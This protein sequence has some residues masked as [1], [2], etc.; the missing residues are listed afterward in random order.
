MQLVESGPEDGIPVVLIHG[1]LSTGR[2]Y[3]HLFDVAPARYRLLAPDMRGF[4][5]T[6]RVPI[7][8]TRGLRDWADDTAALLRRAGHHRAAA[9]RRLVDRRRRDRRVRARPPGRVADVDRSGRPVRL[10]RHEARRHAALRGLRRLR[11]RH[12]QPGVHRAAG[13]RRP[14]RRTA[15]PRRATSEQLLLARR[16]PRAARARGD[17]ARRD[18]EVGRPATTATRATRPPP[19]TGPAS[20]PA[21]AASSTRSPRSTATGRGSSTSTPS[22]RSCGRTA[23]RTSSSP[24]ARRGRWGRSGSLGAVPGLARKELPAAADGH[25]DPRRCCELRARRA[26]GDRDVRGVRPLPAARRA[27]ALE[28][29]V[30]RVPGVRRVSYALPGLRADRSRA[31]G[32]ARPR[33]SRAASRSRSSRAR[34]PSRRAVD[35]PF[36]VFLQGGPGHEASAADRQPARARLAG[37][38]AEGVPRAAARPARHRALDAGHAAARA[39]ST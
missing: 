3:E 39:P 26:R 5:D 13:G 38:R 25:P 30:L 33:R 23:R 27:R 17:A 29:G 16:A 2:F 21:R 7:D 22:R 14:L 10:R 4:G 32:P 36:L 28:R 1:N 37:P 11:R 35:K 18:P 24:T 12:R 9:P 19:S 6:E 8:A 31:D 15:T 20:R 34:S